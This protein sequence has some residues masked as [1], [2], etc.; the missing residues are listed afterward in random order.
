MKTDVWKRVEE[1]FHAVMERPPE[2]RAEFLQRACPDDPPLRSEVQSLINLA[3]SADSFL[4]GSPISSLERPLARKAGERVGN[5]EILE[6]LGCG[7]MGEVWRARDLR[8][9]RQVALKFISSAMTRDRAAAERFERE[10]RAVAA[11]NH[12]N[13]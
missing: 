4:A 12:P 8:L 2:E 5:F 3:R 9:G 10:A 1:L 11:L 7:G 6:P 13:I